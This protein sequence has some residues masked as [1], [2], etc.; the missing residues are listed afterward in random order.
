V[1]KDGFEKKKKDLA[2]GWR[3]DGLTYAG[4]EGPLNKQAVGRVK[5]SIEEGILRIVSPTKGKGEN[6]VQFSV[7]KG[8]EGAGRGGSAPLGIGNTRKIGS[9]KTGSAREERGDE[10]DLLSSLGSFLTKEKGTFHPNHCV[11]VERFKKKLKV[12]R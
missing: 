10:S 1:S 9:I 12:Y 4:F 7:V 8:G 3:Y 5:R 11:W 2:D 6:R